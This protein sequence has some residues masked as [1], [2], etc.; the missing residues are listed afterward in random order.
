MENN[1]LTERWLT[2]QNLKGNFERLS[3]PELFSAFERND[4]FAFPALLPHQNG[5]W[6]VFLV[7]LA[8]HCLETSGKVKELPPPNPR[9][10]WSMLG[11]HTPDE[12]REMIR[13]IVPNYSQDYPHDEPWRLVTEDLSK[14]A[15]M[16]VPAPGKDFDAYKGIE[17]FPDDLDLLVPSKN[18]DIKSGTIRHSSTEMW[19]FALISLQTNSGF[20]GRG[21]YGISRQN[22]GWAIRPILTLQSNPAPGARWARDT[23]VILHCPRDWNLYEFCHNKANKRLLWLDPWDGASSCAMEVLHPLFIEICRRVRAVRCGEKLTVKKA[24]SNCARVDIGKTGGNLRDPWEP[25]SV[26]KECHVFHSKLN[27]SN[28]AKILAEK[29]VKKPLL[30]RY[31]EGIDAP[32]GTKIWCSVLMKGKG[33]T[34]GYEERLIPVDVTSANDEKGTLWEAAE[35]MI[36]LVKTAKNNV[37]AVALARFMLCGKDPDGNGKIDWDSSVVKNWIPTVK[38]RMEDEIETLFFKHLWITCSNI[39]NGETP[40][41]WI[42]PW[43]KCLTQLVQKYYAVGVSSLPCSA[44]QFVKA[45]AL[46]SLILKQLI[47]RYLKPSTEEEK[48][49]A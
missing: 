8:C 20:L 17:E 30:L 4:V 40:E 14:P 21:N 16:Q 18:F 44:S 15:F 38:N 47:V 28:I 19:V 7:Q 46:S 23:Y 13:A 5:P 43:K 26:D 3:L 11:K 25:I 2:V 31:H 49:N 36:N 45:R 34:E 48:I 42:V 41:N 39:R 37:L 10:P 6:H 1:L 35:A 24:V 9:K 12:W 27:Y 22:G 33:K 29:E 32:E